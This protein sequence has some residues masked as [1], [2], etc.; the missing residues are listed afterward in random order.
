MGFA[1][2]HARW[3]LKVGTPCEFVLLN[4]MSRT[5]G[6]PMIEGRDCA[7]IDRSHGPEASQLQELRELLMNNGPRGVTPIAER[8]EDIRRRIQA[9][10]ST[11]AQARQMIF[12]TIVTDGLPTSPHSGTSGPAD[13]KLM[14]ETMRSLCATLPIQMVI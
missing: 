8:L 14:I 11:L 2:D 3:N 5:Q 6:A 4:S 7:H 13:R 1:E 9:N 10:F 12:L